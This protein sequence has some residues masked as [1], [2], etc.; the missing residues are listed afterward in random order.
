M[1]ATI[2]TITFKSEQEASR[3]RLAANCGGKFLGSGAFARTY[4]KGSEVIKVGR[5][6]DAYIQYAKQV[7]KANSRNPFLPKLFGLTIYKPAKNLE[8]GCDGF[9]V[10]R[11]ER[12]YE[13]NSKH[14]DEAVG[15]IVN[16]FEQIVEYNYSLKKWTDRHDPICI[17]GLFEVKA[18]FNKRALKWLKHARS[19]VTKASKY[20]D[21]DIHDGNIM[22]RKNGQ[23]VLTDPIA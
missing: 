12:L 2:E 3:L 18:T 23:L 5:E 7:I 13:L 14:K 15:A 10:V 1:G 21:W 8:W 9:Y 19:I 6:G 16:A 17:P 20:G 11:M 22:V 4:L